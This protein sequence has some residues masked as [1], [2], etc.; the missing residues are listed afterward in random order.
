MVTRSLLNAPRRA[1]IQKEV[2]YFQRNKS[3][4]G[5]ADKLAA[6]SLK[7][8]Y[9]KST[10]ARERKMH[11]GAMFATTRCKMVKNIF[12]DDTQGCYVNGLQRSM[13]LLSITKLHFLGN[14]PRHPAQ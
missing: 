7:N 11:C 13:H 12:S 9:N 2:P 5:Y 4:H 8:C 6:D 10:R 1:T 14:E 3:T